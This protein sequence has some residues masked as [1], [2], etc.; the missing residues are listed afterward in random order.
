MD[1]HPW[2]PMSNP[3]DL[4]H[5]GKLAEEAS[6]LASAAS[7]CIIQGILECEPVNGK[8]NKQWL[9]EEIADVEANIQLVKERFELDEDSIA[10]R[11][12]DKY[13]RLRQWH[14]NTEK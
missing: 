4:K 5:L 6:E 8:S 1:Y 14:R 2:Q 3:T 12:E 13:I 11:M 9:E 7:R 10:T